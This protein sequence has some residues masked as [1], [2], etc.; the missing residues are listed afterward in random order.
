VKFL[1]LLLLSIVMA[2][3]ADRRVAI[4]I[5][6]LPRGDDNGGYT[7]DVIR[8]MTKKLLQPFAA[9]KIPVIG[10]VNEGRVPDLGR[11]NLREIL[12]L[13]LDAGADLGNHSY[14]HPDINTMLLADFEGDILK[15]E[16]VL[17]EALEARGKQLQ[18][19]RHP[20]L[21]V[22][23]TPEAKRGLTTFLEQHHYEVAPVTFN[24]VDYL[25]AAAYVRPEFHDRAKREYVPYM[26]SIVSFY[27]QRSM[28]VFGREIPQVLLIHASQMNAD[29]M[30]ELLAMFRS[31][32]HTFVSLQDALKDDAYRTA[33]PYVGTGGGSW[34]NRWATAK[35]VPAKSGPPTP[36]W[37]P[38][39]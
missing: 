16:P 10:F 26:E 12:D 34:L 20:F 6:D 36:A 9:E 2:S 4:T 28:D 15:G 18:Y 7:M 38:N 22:G 13:W 32:G 30:P 19:F 31:R 25:F 8:Q 3:A 21:R 17:R 29:L 24:D 5:D 23:A 11:K 33:D 27:E 14:S 39:P 1:S 35:G 37:L